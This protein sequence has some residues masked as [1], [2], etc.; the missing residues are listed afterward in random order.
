[1]TAPAFIE[2]SAWV[3]HGTGMLVR[4]DALPYDHPES[5]PSVI[6]RMGHDPAEFGYPVC[7]RCQR[8]LSTEVQP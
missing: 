6:R 5:V 3:G 8:D 1:M 7:A 2:V 4:R